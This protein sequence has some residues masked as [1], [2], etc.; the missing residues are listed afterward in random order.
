M[1]E[2]TVRRDETEAGAQPADRRLIG[3]DHVD[4]IFDTRAGQVHAVR[5]VSLSVR[6]GETLGLVGESGSGKSTVARLMMGLMPPT[7]GTVTFDGVDL[8]TVRRGDL[9]RL[10]AQMQMVFQNPYGSLLPHYSAAGNVAEP[11]RLHK[12]GDKASRRQRAIELLTMVGVNPRFAD[13]YPRQFSG[14]QQ[15]RVAI[16]RA[17]ALEPKLLM[18]DEPTSSLDVSIQAQVLALLDELRTALGLTVVFI[19]HNL[20]VVERFADRVAVMCLGQVVEV[21]PTD[22]L[23]DTPRHPYTQQLLAAVLP[24]TRDPL[25]VPADP[26][27]PQAVDLPLREVAPGH[28]VRDS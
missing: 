5:D 27:R 26:W 3:V 24:V 17:L 10:R 11:L 9:R 21:A 16:A 20:A 22:V 6:H 8:A 4:K 18:C 25:P 12:R 7:R 2:L 28:Y 15:Q 13:H 19:S 14:G 1:S 23:F